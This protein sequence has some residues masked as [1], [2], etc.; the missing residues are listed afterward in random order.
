MAERDSDPERIS[1]EIDET[2]RRLRETIGALEQKLSAGQ[3]VHD[4][5][6]ALRKAVVGPH[7]GSEPMIETLK[8]NPIPAALIGVGLGWLCLSGMT[9]A[10]K[11]TG[12]PAAPPGSRDPL[13]LGGLGLLAGALLGAVLPMTRRE[14]EWLGEAHARL[15]DEADA[16]GRVAMARAWAVAE[17][18]GRAAIDAVAQELGEAVG[19][20]RANGAD[21]T[22]H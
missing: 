12:A 14:P 1:A 10:R 19:A 9:D 3:I 7:N 4:A 8:R 2:H 15:V 18:A 11:P 5:V 17:H 21:R 16:L 20:P 13:V 22:P 6:D